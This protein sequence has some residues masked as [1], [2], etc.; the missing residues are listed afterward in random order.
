MTIDARILRGPHAP[1]RRRQLPV[2]ALHGNC[3]RGAPSTVADAG[4]GST[5]IAA[6]AS[7]PV[8]AG[9]EAAHDAAKAEGY[10][11]GYREGHAEAARR[12]EEQLNLAR[13]SVREDAERLQRQLSERA[14]QEAQLIAELQRSVMQ[15]VAQRLDALEPGAIELAFT[16]LCKVLG[17][18]T[19]RASLLSGL[20]R[21][22]MTQMRSAKPVMIQLNPASL[23]LIESRCAKLAEE[24]ACPSVEWI[25]DA[26]LPLA[27]CTLASDQGQLDAALQTQLDSL[28]ALWSVAD[29]GAAS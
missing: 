29:S 22:A 25:A 24:S 23:A 3:A 11:A 8:R 14:Q 16:A 21:Q 7:E 27:G 6:Q 20:I 13:H 2:A 5:S 1:V 28:R 18:D 9:G 19:D 12:C 15:A 4:T 10:A 17:P 26:T